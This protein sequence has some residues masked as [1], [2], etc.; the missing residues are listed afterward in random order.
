L[1]GVP[2]LPGVHPFSVQLL[3]FSHPLFNTLLYG[4]LPPK[5]NTPFDAPEWKRHKPLIQNHL[6]VKKNKRR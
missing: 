3:A 2:E 1:H 4:N 5:F 6:L